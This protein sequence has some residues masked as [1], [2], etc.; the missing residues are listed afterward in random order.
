MGVDK[1]N[2]LKTNL[3]YLNKRKKELNTPYPKLRI[4]TVG[5]LDM[6]DELKLSINFAEEF[7]AIEGIQ[8]TSFKSFSSELNDLMPL[9][10][11]DYFTKVTN[12]AINYAKEKNIKFVLQSE[13]FIEN[14]EESK[15]LGHKNCTMPWYRLSIQSNG[16]VYPCPVSYRAIGNIFKDDIIEIWNSKNMV[17]F[18]SGVNSIDEMNDD[19]KNCTHCRHRSTINKDTNDFSKKNT[20]IS[21]M[22]R[23]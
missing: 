12:D 9:N 17:D 16:D 7:H 8:V 21:G 6:I 14:I 22:T 13:G 3:A 23:K 15:E 20:Y 10:D 18:R 1:F 2:L 11:R 19:C 5:L 4:S